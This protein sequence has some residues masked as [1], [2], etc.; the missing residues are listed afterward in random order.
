MPKKKKVLFWIP[1]PPGEAPSQR[2]RFEQYFLALDQHHI[3]YKLAPFLDDHTWRILYHPGKVVAKAWG[4]LKGFLKRLWQV[5]AVVPQYDFVFVH[6]EAAP[7][8]PPVFEWMAAKI[9]RKKLIYDFDDA[10]WLANTSEQNKIAAGLKWHQKVGSIC[11]WAWK[12]SCGNRYLCQYAAQFNKQVVHNPTTIDTVHLHNPYLYPQQQKQKIVIGWTGTH[13]TMPY[14]L[15]LVPVLQR[16]EEQFDFEFCVISN[17]NPELPLKSFSFRKWS[18]ETEIADLR[19]FDI[20]VMPLTDDKWAKG[21]CGFKALQYM[22]LEVPTLVSPVGVNT[23]IIEHGV[24][25]YICSSQEE[26]ETY[27]RQL[28]EGSTN[29]KTLGM[30]A[31]ETVEARYSVNSN[32]RTFL[33]LFD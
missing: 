23:E 28:L 19:Y 13:S 2:F 5:L 22:S 24:N 12:V 21:K 27:L 26:W 18:K 15:P 25:G 8:G 16:L 14:L 17:Q 3:D 11:Q 6:R 4:I 29:S 9:W 30:V 7:L 33:S 32:T 1:Y 10:I 31:R 20:G